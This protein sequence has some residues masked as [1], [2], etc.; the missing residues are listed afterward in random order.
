[1]T[2]RAT[3]EETTHVAGVTTRL[4]RCCILVQLGG[5]CRTS[6]STQDHTFQQQHSV[7]CISIQHRAHVHMTLLIIV[8]PEHIH[9]VMRPSS[10]QPV[11]TD[12]IIVNSG[13][14]LPLPLPLYRIKQSESQPFQP[15]TFTPLPGSLGWRHQTRPFATPFQTHHAFLF[16]HYGP[17]SPSTGES[18]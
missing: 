3:T 10:S 9:S 18:H 17:L 1:M 13:G 15:C 4:S 2:D 5:V 12:H 11:T 14:D 7:A 8:A 16:L 6:S